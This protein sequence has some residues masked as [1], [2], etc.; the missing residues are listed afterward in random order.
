[1]H[2]I[3][4]ALLVIF[5][6]AALMRMDWAYYLVYV[7]GGVW[8]FSHWWV[9]RSLAR[10]HMTR[11]ITRYAF[12]NEH[13]SVRIELENRSWLPLPWLQ[14]QEAVPLDLKDQE[15]YRTI[16]S[17]GGRSRLVHDYTLY[18]RR[19]GY[20][21]VGPLNLRTSDL[22]GFVEARWE[23]AGSAEF[24]VYPQIVPLE[25]L[26]LS[27]RAPFGVL[28]VRRQMSED[29]ARLSGVRA[30]AAGDSLRRIHWKA[31]AHADEL[32]VKKFH[33]SQ[34]LPAL[35]VLDLDRAAYPV[36]VLIGA[37]EWAISVAASLAGHLSEQRQA[38][39]L[40]ANGSDPLAVGD[41]PPTILP[42][43]GREHLMSL[44]RL[45]A[46]IQLNGAAQ[47]LPELITRRTVDLPWG[48]TLLVATPHL[49]EASL[50]VLHNAY[51]RGANVIAFICA[52]QP[53]FRALQSRGKRLGVQLFHTVWERDLQAVT[54]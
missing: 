22:F 32:L 39:G 52:D 34:D 29:P 7:V 31:T 41:G 3:F 12:T 8:V 18:C 17:L 33:S 42:H 53:N 21:T 37:S 25:R 43:T 47:P 13:A 9:R 51:R 20:Y 4:W 19:R 28:G 14:I 26:G 35:I 36:R 45:L 16:V 27:S 30:Y 11:R 10:L 40:V 1:M 6:V 48:A 24:I 44:W 15:D 50:W 46:R 23:E 38:V 5:L 49:D 54:T 2:N